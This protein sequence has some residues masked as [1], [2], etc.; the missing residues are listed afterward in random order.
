M[1]FQSGNIEPE[2]TDVYF[3]LL[4]DNE[5]VLLF[6]TP[7]ACGYR[8]CLKGVFMKNGTSLQRLGCVACF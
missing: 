5:L 1:I 2:S 8:S 4:A 7:P 3:K 6:D